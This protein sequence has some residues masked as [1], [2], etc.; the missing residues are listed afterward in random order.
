MLS[1]FVGG[2]P[3]DK[4]T[5]AEHRIESDQPKTLVRGITKQGRLNRRRASLWHSN[6]K[7]QLSHDVPSLGRISLELPLV[8]ACRLNPQRFAIPHGTQHLD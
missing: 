2:K 6:M 4:A 7:N 5:T 1:S 3:C 8:P